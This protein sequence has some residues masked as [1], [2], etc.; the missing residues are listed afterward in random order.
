LGAENI[1]NNLFD[2]IVGNILSVD[3]IYFA[4]NFL[5]I[6]GA[7]FK[8]RGNGYKPFVDIYR[9]IGLQSIRS[10]SRPIVLV[11]GRQIGMTTAAAALEMYFA[12][13]G[14]F[15]NKKAPMRLIHLFPTLS[16]AAAFTKDKLNSMIS[17]SKEV[18]GKPRKD[19]TPKSF[20]ESKLDLSSPSNNSQSFKRFLGGNQIWIESVGIDGDRI[21]GRTVDAAFYDEV[22]D[23]SVEAIGASTKILTRAKYGPSG[24]GLQ[25]FFGTP[26]TKNG[27]Y[28]EMWKKSTQNYYHLGCEKCNA[29]FPIYKPG[30]NWEEVWIYGTVVRCPECH[31]EQDRIQAIERGQW[32]QL[33]DDPDK[34]PYIGYHFN[35]LLIPSFDG[36]TP[37]K[38]EDIESSKPENSIN[39]ERIYT[40]EVLGEFF[41]GSSGLIELEEIHQNCADRTRRVAKAIHPGAKI[42]AFAGFDWGQ[43]SAWDQL[44]SKSKQQGKSYSCGVVL[45][46]DKDNHNIFNVQFA[47]RLKKNDMEDKISIVDEM[48]RRY[49]LTLSVGDIGD[50][51]DLTHKLQQKYDVKFLASRASHR[52]T[53]HI[54][55]S[56]DE[57]PKIIVFERD[58]Y[59]SELIGLLKEGKIK[60]PYKSYD[61]ID[62]LV[63][64]CTNMDIKITRDKSGEPIKKYVKTGP[65]DGFMAL[66]NAYLAWKFT[67]TN[68]FAIKSPQNMRY[69]AGRSNSASDSAVLGYVPNMFGK[70]G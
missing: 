57:F 59:I 24:K 31:H 54:K 10:N 9:Y 11:K 25:V 65:N 26:K 64:H 53:G 56:Q 62:W 60:F 44:D 37:A 52:I 32:I 39:T 18:P 16:L 35:Q 30:I 47:T 36:V 19:G 49:S 7:P 29:L 55:Y 61:R 43:K 69:E 58:Y 51:N 23:M 21:R 33:G 8:M 48:F 27:P 5:T 50:A 13:C 20:L 6:D 42:Q 12:T 1:E 38:K 2:D 34:A 68:G 41:S 46:V 28:W 15:G 3:P 40:T 70:S 22:Q 63:H 45:T 66:L 17:A 14:F 4:E 67:V